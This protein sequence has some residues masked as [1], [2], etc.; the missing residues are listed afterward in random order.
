MQIICD[1]HD[2][3]TNC[4]WKLCSLTVL[5]WL[6]TQAKQPANDPAITVILH[7]RRQACMKIAAV[8][9]KRHLAA[10][11]WK[12]M[13]AKKRGSLKS[14]YLLKKCWTKD[15][16]AA[17]HSWGSAEAFLSWVPR[18][19]IIYWP[20]WVLLFT[21]KMVVRWQCL[22]N[23]CLTHTARHQKSTLTTGV[24]VDVRCAWRESEKQLRDRLICA[25]S[26]LI[27]WLSI[28]CRVLTDTPVPLIHFHAY[29]LSSSRCL[30]IYSYIQMCGHTIKAESRCL[31][32]FNEDSYYQA[33][34]TDKSL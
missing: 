11:V 25:Q 12:R 7:R 17:G 10:N 4:R 8:N 29:F 15:A 22:R 23:I 5:I 3:F 2:C 9:N 18:P 31:N 34:P 16:K 1:V 26:V 33:T 6:G 19:R 14:S 24:R 28:F 20:N 27:F 13:A 32:D 21:N 30:Y